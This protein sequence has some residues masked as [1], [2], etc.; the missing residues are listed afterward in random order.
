MESRSSSQSDSWLV[1]LSARRYALTCALVSP[2]AICTG[3]SLSLSLCAASSRV[4]PAMITCSESV[5]IA[6]RNPNS[7]ILAA[8]LSTAAGGIFLALR[9]YG[10]ILSR[11][12]ISIFMLN[13]CHCGKAMSREIRFGFIHF[14]FYASGIKVHTIDNKPNTCQ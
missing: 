6:L 9:A 4:C 2:V 8:T 11:G 3:T 13:L 7:L 14:R 10:T 1:L 12:N 5:T